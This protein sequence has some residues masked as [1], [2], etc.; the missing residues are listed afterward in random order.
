MRDRLL[1]KERAEK[2]S[3]SVCLTGSRN[4]ILCLCPRNQTLQHGDEAG[5][6]LPQSHSAS[7]YVFG[8][9]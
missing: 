5:Q 3:V 7:T 1:E 6:R 4:L 8:G 9:V 2:D